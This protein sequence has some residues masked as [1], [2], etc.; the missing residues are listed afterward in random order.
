MASSN[1]RRSSYALEVEVVEVE[2][3]EHLLEEQVSQQHHPRHL[4]C[5]PSHLAIPHPLYL[6]S[7]NKGP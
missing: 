1:V 2:V 3:E 4:Q 6:T 5:F 7:A